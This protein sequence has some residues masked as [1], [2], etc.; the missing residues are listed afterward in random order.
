VFLLFSVIGYYVDI[1]KGNGEMPYLAVL[2][3][4]AYSGL[5]ALL[6]IFV[7]ARLPRLFLIPLVVLQ[8]FNK[9]IY[10][11]LPDFAA[12]TFKLHPVPSHTGI[13]FA[14][15]A[16]MWTV[17]VSYVSFGL[18]ISREGRES[19]RMQNELELAHGIQKT[20]VPPVHLQT[21]CFEVYGV[22]FPS[23]KVGGDLVDV[24]PWPNGDTVA[25][26]AD[27]SG[28][29]IQAG[30]L[31]GMLKTATRTALLDASEREPS[32]T[33]PILLD[34]LNS[35]LPGVKEAHMY[36]TFAGIRLGADGQVFYALAASP[37]LLHWR[38][39]DRTFSTLDEEQFPVGLLPVS[40]FGGHSLKT[41]QGDLLVVATDG[42]LE[43]C[44]RAGEEFGIGRLKSLVAGRPDDA[45]PELASII[46]AE[47]KNFGPRTDDQSLLIVR[48][49]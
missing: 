37:P 39:H 25:Y 2:M 1:V 16:M 19:F 36:A 28:H 45:L 48:Y 13:E 49:L 4:A 31:M 10:G 18:F 9:E 7:L 5:D 11:F 3:I 32:Q 15:S 29:G 30:I 14:A 27:V 33:L 44:N 41:Q 26:L 47:A 40:C 6:W 8:F 12:H 20:L 23:E 21:G 34:R 22:S 35:V 43:T 42:I 24:M 46:L 38:A 17:I